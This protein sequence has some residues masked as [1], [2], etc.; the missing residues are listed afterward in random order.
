MRS[1]EGG[2]RA[3]KERVV[4]RLSGSNTGTVQ[5]HRGY[6]VGEALRLSLNRR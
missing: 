4:M 6:P 1:T 2:Q 3:E 5:K